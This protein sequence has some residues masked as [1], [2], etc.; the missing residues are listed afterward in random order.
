MVP[1]GRS[2]EGV[3]KTGKGTMSEEVVQLLKGTLLFRGL[4][5]ETLAALAPKIRVRRLSANDVLMRKGE[6]GDSLFMIHDG[7]VKIVTRDSM[8][9]ELIINKCGPGETIGEMALLEQAPRSAGAVAL[10]DVRVLELKKDAFLEIINQR[11]DV[12]LAII[13]YISSRLRFSTT[14]IEKTIE[15]S[16][17]LAA[18]DYAFIENN[19]I[20]LNKVTTGEDKA[21]QLLAAFFQMV[22]NVKEREEALKQQLSKLEFEIDQKRR[23]QDFEQIAGTEFYS[24]LKELAKRLRAERMQDSEQ[25]SS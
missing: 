12:S 22:K 15:W 18:G 17:R 6:R 1:A 10:G 23:K 7:W 13:L 14:Y 9:G 5:D 21:G 20:D 4:P 19:Q 25:D 3:K 2:F 16:H 11:P 24:K 8:G